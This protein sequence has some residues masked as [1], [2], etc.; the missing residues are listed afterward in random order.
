MNK[1]SKTQMPFGYC[2]QMASVLF[3]QAFIGA[4]ITLFCHEKSQETLGYKTLL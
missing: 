3:L 2:D 4:I 1:L